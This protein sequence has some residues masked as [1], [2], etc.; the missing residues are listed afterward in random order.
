[1]A[2]SIANLRRM[3][4]IAPDPRWVW[5]TPAPVCEDRVAAYPPFRFGTSTWRNTD[6]RAFA[7]AMRGLDGTLIDLVATFGAPAEPALQ[8]ADGIHP[9]LAG[10]SAIVRSLV[11]GLAPFAPVR[12]EAAR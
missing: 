11:D 3:Q 9:T 8:G 6:V 12:S 4:A 5:M 2:E 7:D 10:Q 1:L